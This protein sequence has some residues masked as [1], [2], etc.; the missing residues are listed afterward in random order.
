[1]TRAID[2]VEL[3]SRLI[4]CPSVTPARGLVFDTLESA[5]TPLGF[6]VH[7]FVSGEVENLIATRGSGAPHFG[8]AGH[9]DVVPAGRRLERRRLPPRDSRRPALRA[10]ARS[11]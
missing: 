9:L 4:A 7:R 1:M 11:T 5:L 6:E 3:A 8:F 2:P 10:R